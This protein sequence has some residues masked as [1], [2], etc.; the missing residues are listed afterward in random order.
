MR[1]R[2]IVLA[3]S[4]FALGVTLAGCESFD[5]SDWFNQKK[6][7]PGDRKEVFPGGVP[8]VPQGVPPE[9]VQ[10]YQP[11]S[12]PPPQAAPPVEEKPKPKPKPKPKVAVKPKPA[13]APPPA[14][15]TVGPRQTPPSSPWPNPQ[16]AGQPAPAQSDSAFPDPPRP[17]R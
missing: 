4:L 17:Q 3:V 11:P 15:I 2:R 16:T 9:L 5:P 7:L 8:G 14:Q 12:E 13:P 1:H 10:G 6:P